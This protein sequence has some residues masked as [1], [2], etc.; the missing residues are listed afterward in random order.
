LSGEEEGLLTTDGM[1]AG[2]VVEGSVTREKYLEFLE[3]MVVSVLT[4]V[5]ISTHRIL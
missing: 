4:H 5:Y 3:L 2:L 1:V